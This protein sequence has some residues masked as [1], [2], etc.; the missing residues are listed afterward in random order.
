[1]VMKKPD[2]ESS[3]EPL[4]YGVWIEGTGWLRD[5]NGRYFADPRPEYAKAA[6]RMWNVEGTPRARIELIDESMVGLQSTFLVRE[7]ERWLRISRRS[8]PVSSFFK[9]IRNFIN[10]L[11]RHST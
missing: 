1:M 9:N 3:M 4:T 7:K 10:G 11:L 5:P 2:N 8:N 6:L